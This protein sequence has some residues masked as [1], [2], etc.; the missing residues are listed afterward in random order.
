[1]SMQVKITVTRERSFERNEIREW[2]DAAWRG[3]P[4]RREGGRRGRV[5]KENVSL[6]QPRS[7]PL[8]SAFDATA[9]IFTSFDLVF[10]WD[11][12]RPLIGGPW[13]R[14]ARKGDSLARALSTLMYAR[15][16]HTYVPARVHMCTRL[17]ADVC[18]YVCAHVYIRVGP[19]TLHV[20]IR[21]YIRPIHRHRDVY[22]GWGSVRETAVGFRYDTVDRTARIFGIG[23]LSHGKISVCATGCLKNISTPFTGVSVHL[24]T[25]ARVHTRS[26]I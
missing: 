18:I 13:P 5:S 24:C 3:L 2:R 20:Y 10:R 6:D 15:C 4:R 25:Y 11:S 22:T 16:E 8:A 23:A 7:S 21:E 26:L 12:P 9:E 14:P 19:Q 17:F 1:M